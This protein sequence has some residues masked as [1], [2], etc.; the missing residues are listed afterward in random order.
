M[1]TLIMIDLWNGL[2]PAEF[3][4]FAI[5][6]DVLT[7]REL[8]L[9]AVFCARQVEHLVIDQRSREAINVAERLADGKATETERIAAFESA[10]HAA[11]AADKIADVHIKSVTDKASHAAL[12][13]ILFYV[14]DAAL[15][16]Y[17]ESAIAAAE[18]ADTPDAEF[19]A[20]RAA[21]DA[22]YAAQAAWLRAN[23][24]PKFY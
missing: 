12:Y 21:R 24:N 10:W 15:C 17:R 16:V 11:T 18:A 20:A 22:A 6:T 19:G 2:K 13:A 3:L 8:R 4:P 9:F 14:K 5:G 7:D 1:R 23:T